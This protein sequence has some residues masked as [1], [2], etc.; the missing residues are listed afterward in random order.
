M[1]MQFP[2]G[3]NI[4]S[5][6]PIDARLVLT[7]AQMRTAHIDYLMPDKY[8]ALCST[9]GKL[10]I[11]DRHN[12]I[13]GSTGR[14]R[15]L[16]DNTPISDNETINVEV[17]PNNETQYV[18]SI[19]GK[20]EAVNQ[21]V[22]RKHIIDGE[23]SYSWDVIY[24]KVQVDSF[25]AQKV[26][27]E[28]N[29]SLMSAAEHEKLAG[30]PATA[31]VVENSGINGNIIVDGAETTVYTEPS[32]VVHDASY[33]HTDNN[34]T[35]AEVTKL[36]GIQA[37][38]EVN[39]II[40]V[41]V[42]TDNGSNYNS[43]LDNKVAQIDLSGKENIIGPSHKISLEYTEETAGRKWFTT[44]DKNKLDAIPTGAEANLVNDVRVN[45]ES[46][47]Q[48]KIAKLVVEQNLSE[49]SN[50]PA[51]TTAVR[52]FV[53]SSVSAMSTNYVTSNAAGDSFATLTALY[54]ASNYYYNGVIYTPQQNDYAIVAVDSGHGD[55]QARYIYTLSDNVGQW[56]FQYTLGDTFT[57]AQMDA[58]NSGINSSA[59]NKLNNIES[60]AQVNNITNIKVNNVTQEIVDKTVNIAVP[61]GALAALNQVSEENLVSALWEKIH[62]HGS[63]EQ[64]TLLNNITA[65]NLLTAEQRE[66]IAAV[67]G[68]QD[69]L[70]WAG[71]YVYDATNNKVVTD[72]Y[73]TSIINTVKQFNYQVTQTL[74]EATKANMG[75]IWL[76][77]PVGLDAYD[78]YLIIEPTTGTYV[79]EKLGTAQID[80]SQYY[81]KSEVNSMIDGINGALANKVDA[82]NG[83]SLI[84]TTKINKL[85]GIAAGAQVNVIESIK[86]NNTEITPDANKAVNIII[87]TSNFATKDELGSLANVA[88]T[89]SYTDLSNTP[90]IPAAVTKQTVSDW[91]FSEIPASNSIGKILKA[92]GLTQGAFAWG[93]DTID[94]SFTVTN[95]VGGWNLGDTITADMTIKYILC[96]LLKT[97]ALDSITFDDTAAKKAYTV[98]EAFDTAHLVVYAHYDDSSVAEVT[99]YTIQ[100]ALITG[101]TTA[102]TISYTEQNVTKTTS[103]NINPSETEYTIS[104]VVN[105]TLYGYSAHSG[106]QIQQNIA[107]G[108][109][110]SLPI[111]LNFG[112]SAAAIVS[113]TADDRSYYDTA[114]IVSENNQSYV[115]ITNIRGNISFEVSAFLI[116]Y[117]V[118]DNVTHGAISENSST[119]NV[120][121][122]DYL[123]TINPNAKYRMPSDN[124]MVVTGI[125]NPTIKDGNISFTGSDITGNISI[126]TSCPVATIKSVTISNASPS[127]FEAGESLNVTYTVVYNDTQSPQTSESLTNNSTIDPPFSVVYKLDNTE[128]ASNYVFIREDAGTNKTLTVEY[129]NGSDSTESANKSITV[130]EPE[131]ILNT[132]NV[133]NCTVQKDSGTWTTGNS[134]SVELTPSA[135]Y[136]LLQDITASSL[137]GATFDSYDTS[138]GIMYFTNITGDITVKNITCVLKQVTSIAVATAPSDIKYT[139]NNTVFKRNGLTLTATYNDSSTATIQGNDSRVSIP[140]VVVNTNNLDT[141]QSYTITYTEAG[142]A[143][144]TTQDVQIVKTVT[145]LAVKTRGEDTYD[146]NDSLDLTGWVLEATYNNLNDS[147]AEVAYTS[148]NPA[149]GTPLTMATTQI[150]FTYSYTSFGDSSTQ[151]TSANITINPILVSSITIGSKPSAA[152]HVGDIHQLTATVLPANAT[153]RAI[154][155][156]SSDISVATV[157]ST[158]LITALAAGNTTITATA[159]DGSGV[160]D[161]CSI[162]IV[163]V[164]QVVNWYVGHITNTSRTDFKAKTAAELEESAVA[165]SET[166]ATW[167]PAAAKDICYLLIRDGVVTPSS[168]TMTSGGLTTPWTGADIRADSG[169][170]SPWN[171]SG[172][173]GHTDIQLN[174]TTYHVYAYYMSTFNVGADIITINIVNQ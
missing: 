73:L 27:K 127:S 120:E 26:D 56:N 20:D 137:E 15:L 71:N 8:I 89:G 172:A 43:V 95:P 148:S 123:I 102:I 98:G 65:N 13:L 136:V 59:V 151:T 40:D 31:T 3:F 7:V 171:T 163:A 17:N 87:D 114:T 94:S 147:K 152:L 90:T 166:S 115:Q 4:R 80:L 124:D 70:A 93:E 79:R 96:K 133:N 22:L 61:T 47:I 74:P 131:F 42:R 34:F 162:E 134:G 83:K 5:N 75:I 153:D 41:Q 29:K 69:T 99:N 149:N 139:T 167:T 35:D 55:K 68:K 49:D 64:V 156:T 36:A 24:D 106:S 77:K 154:N 72:Q 117:S 48:D 146:E 21:A 86:V 97:A 143:K 60:G 113:V 110:Y 62:S 119:F 63:Q 19:R 66:A 141:T 165:Q 30:I 11:Y 118:T 57:S 116:S 23:V 1:A 104:A 130:I 128:I 108:N 16:K 78:E 58:I 14:F 145:N 169:A 132:S 46:I 142:V 155:W 91:G 109:T 9:D 112:Y 28:A 51:S 135:G 161:T 129:S 52:A 100:P 126:T 103:I 158:G 160:S 144:T 150:D 140:N 2:Y 37:N 38:A 138:S 67:A 173:N 82:E 174:G 164:P 44:A 25:L 18:L 76:Y 54:S 170:S 125:N 45:N 50:N 53:N 33:V 122:T 107:V 88:R 105:G 157:S 10:Y 111:D 101:N 39:S 12:D 92:T 81:T 85:D 84:E 159:H 121:G 6:E 32:D 168:A